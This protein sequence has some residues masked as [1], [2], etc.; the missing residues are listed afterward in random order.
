[1]CDGLPDKSYSLHE[2]NTHA[3]DLSSDQVNPSDFIR[4]V[5]TG[6]FR[7]EHQADVNALMN[8]LEPHNSISTRRDYPCI[9]GFTQDITI[10]CPLKLYPISDPRDAISTTSIRVQYDVR[11]RLAGFGA[12]N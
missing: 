4:Y 12:L 1:M 2:F 8:S 10:S 7:G 3:E 5:L 6:N 9:L 11:V